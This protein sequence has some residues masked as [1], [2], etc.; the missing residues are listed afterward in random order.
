MKF[1]SKLSLLLLSLFFLC[2]Q[3]H[4]YADEHS[5]FAEI[6][7]LKLETE[8]KNDI[9]PIRDEDP[10]ESF[11][12]AMFDFNMEFNDYIGEPAAKAYKNTIPQPIQTG[13]NNFFS[14]LKTPLSSI[15]SF[16]QGNVEDGLSSFMRFT[17]N[18]T[19]GLLG[20]LDVATPA[21]LPEI[22]EDLGQTL[23]IWGVW[24][25]TNYIV[26]PFLGP[27]T[28]R[29][30]VTSPIEGY[31]N[32]I[33][34]YVIDTNMAGR[35][36]IIIGSGFTSYASA[37]GLIGQLKEQPDPYIFAR[38]SYLQYRKNLIYNGNPPQADLDDFNFD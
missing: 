33:Y 16:L 2:K 1:K 27:S 14:N 8:I 10:Y 24:K 34:P 28:S 19:F 9:E 29:S 37:I 7:A 32:P 31:S 30:L 15:N 13:L 26:L 20:L 22:D 21:G 23:Y 11:N 18:S 5:L 35:S 25:E 3:T 38:E 17:I 36:L 12:R 4:V 6:E